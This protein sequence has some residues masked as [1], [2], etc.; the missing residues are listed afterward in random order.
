MSLNEPSIFQSWKPFLRIRQMAIA[1]AFFRAIGWE[2]F[3]YGHAKIFGI[4]LWHYEGTKDS[5]FKYSRLLRK[6]GYGKTQNYALLRDLVSKRILRR[7]Y[8]GA[9][10][11]SDEYLGLVDSVISSAKVFTTNI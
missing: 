3:Y 9:Y 4:I 8:N 7:R 11:I 1:A 6:H 10:V 5:S 2:D